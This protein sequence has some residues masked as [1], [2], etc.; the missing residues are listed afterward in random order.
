MEN[1]NIIQLRNHHL[2]KGRKND[3][4]PIYPIT[5]SKAVRYKDPN[6]PDI[7][8][9]YDAIKESNGVTR[10]EGLPESGQSGKIYYNTNDSSYYTYDEANGKFIPLGTTDMLYVD[11]SEEV[12]PNTYNGTS[13]NSNS[14]SIPIEPN[15]YYDFGVRPI[16]VPLVYGLGV[17][18]IKLDPNV[19][20][21]YCGRFTVASDANVDNFVFQLVNKRVGGT[22]M[23]PMFIPDNMGNNNMPLHIGGSVPEFEAGHTY[24]FTIVYDT[25]VFL[26]ITH[27]QETTNESP[28]ER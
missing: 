14:L 21:Q 7:K 22:G 16:A 9:I 2:Q 3:R 25:C 8:T 1:D 26:D 23:F 18:P 10:V 19:A 5:D 24:E 12:E 20:Y 6:N 27:P 4:T 11:Y 28:R 17:L 13:I 15:K